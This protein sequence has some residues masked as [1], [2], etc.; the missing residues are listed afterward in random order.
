MFRPSQA[1]SYRAVLSLPGARR[2]FVAATVGRLSYGT[3]GLSLLLAVHAVTH[4]FAAA[5]AASGGYAVG[6]LTGPAKSRLAD[7]YGQRRVLPVLGAAFAAVLAI[8]AVLADQGDSGPAGYVA[9]AAVAGAVAPLLGSAMRALWAAIVGP[10][11]LPRAYSLDTAVEEGLYTLGPLMVGV[12]V[13]LGGP[14]LALIVTAAL[15]ATGTAALATSPAIAARRVPATPAGHGQGDHNGGAGGP[16]QAS[17]HR[18]PSGRGWAGPLRKPGF[19]GLLSVVLA[20]SLGMGAIDVTITARAVQD[21]DAAAAGYILAAFGLGSALSGVAWGRLRLKARTSTQLTGLLLV[22][23]VGIA[24]SAA[25]PD[26]LVLGV[27]M[28]MTSTAVS[29]LLVL[30]YLSADRLNDQAGGTEAT[31]W[32]NTAFNAGTA[33]GY[34]LTGLAVDRIGTAPPILAGA[35]VLLATAG[36]VLTFRDAYDEAA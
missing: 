7:R 34:G 24:T 4:S 16:G 13:A 20:A 35:V 27:V 1:R 19:P 30:S 17:G 5:G 3:V 23:A 12:I 36:V 33:A 18:R 8:M 6:T 28:A 22:L 29:P 11:D 32:V 2:A 21:H 14:V 9:L 31:T 26:L 15:L 25:A 10:A